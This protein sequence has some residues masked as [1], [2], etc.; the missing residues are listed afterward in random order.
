MDTEGTLAPATPAA[1]REEYDT[2][3]PA[4]KVAVREATRAMA[5][6]RE[7]YA[8]RVTGEVI[9]TV[10]DA[11]FASL[12]RVHVGTREE[13]EAWLDDHPEYESDVAGSDNV[14]NVVWHPVAFA[15]DGE[16]EGERSERTKPV[17]AATWQAER[18]AALGT[19]RRRAFGRAY[20]PVVDSGERDGDDEAGIEPGTNDGSG[21]P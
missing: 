3:V 9:E 16:G 12:L 10:R 20:R 5:F 4:A 2:L 17:V 13:Y 11:L 8:E 1:A 14:D 18:E 15:P 19:L 7:E 21:E 6:D